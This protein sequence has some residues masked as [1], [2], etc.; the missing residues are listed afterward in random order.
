MNETPD[1]RSAPA[2]SRDRSRRGAQGAARAKKAERE[3]R[4]IGLLSRGVSM[5]EIAAGEARLGQPHAQGR[6]R[7]A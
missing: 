6:A 7:R 4:I 1:A 5:A 2:P 3:T